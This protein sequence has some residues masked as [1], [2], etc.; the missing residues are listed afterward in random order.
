MESSLPA[1]GHR[2]RLTVA[3][4]NTMQGVFLLTATTHVMESK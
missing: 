1:C 2:A 3:T 4:K